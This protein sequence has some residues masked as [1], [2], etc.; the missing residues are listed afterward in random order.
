MT[1]YIRRNGCKIATVKTPWG[2]WWQTGSDVFIEV[3][4]PSNTLRRHCRFTI[5]PDYIEC[6][7]RGQVIFSGT[8]YKTVHANESIC[9]VEGNRISITLEKVENEKQWVSLLQQYPLD[10]HEM[11]EKLYSEKFHAEDLS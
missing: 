7:V 4:I 10:Q 1:N 11:F 8:L 2:Q 6:C 9:I 3:D 5:K